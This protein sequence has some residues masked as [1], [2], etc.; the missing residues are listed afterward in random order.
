MQ[1]NLIILSLLVLLLLSG[2]AVFGVSIFTNLFSG[3]SPSNSKTANEVSLDLASTPVTDVSRYE[4]I[5]RQFPPDS[6]L[7]KHFP[8]VIPENAKNVQFYFLPGFLQG[9]SFI[10]L[11]MQ[12]PSDRI[13][14]LQAQF[15]KAAKRKY[16]PGAKDNS[17]LEETSPTGLGITYEYHFYRGDASSDRNFPP[18]YEILVLEDTRGAPKYDWNHPELYGVAL[19][20]STSEIVY[21]AEAW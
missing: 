11:R 6:P 1:R 19:D 4:E 5:R 18:H 2:V 20:V 12:L 13:K 15:R 8:L 3:R 21:W 14:S 16:I 17:P 7:I 9:G 10:Q